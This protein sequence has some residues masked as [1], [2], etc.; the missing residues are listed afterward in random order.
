M[1]RLEDRRPLL[2]FSALCLAALALAVLSTVATHQARHFYLVWNLTLALVPLGCALAINALADRGRERLAWALGVPWLLFLPNAPYILTDF[3]HLQR[4]HHPWAWGHLLLL[5]WFSFAG[6]TSGILA[7]HIVHRLVRER[8]NAMLG[9][10][11]VGGISLLTGLGV[12]LGRFRR[13]NSW[14]IL[15]QPG[16]IASDILGHLPVGRWSVETLV[17]WGLGAFFGFAYL[18]F[19]SLRPLTVEVGGGGRRDM[20]ERL[21]PIKGTGDW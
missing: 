6:L 12:G 20:T 9:W 14:D 13:W 2:A 15:H 5:V 19:W 18:L 21:K 1:T 16:H 8:S 7:L 4:T 10:L 3:I 17:P 11:F